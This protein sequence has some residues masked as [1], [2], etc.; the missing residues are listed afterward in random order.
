MRA[1]T[2]WAG[3]DFSLR[4]VTYLCRSIL[5]ATIHNVLWHVTRLICIHTHVRTES[6]VCTGPPPSSP[7]S[8]SKCWPRRVMIS[9]R[10]RVGR[11]GCHCE[12]SGAMARACERA[13]VLM[14]TID[15]DAM[16]KSTC[17]CVSVCV[18][19]CVCVCMLA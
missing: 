11:F 13:D 16:C 4:A 17:V 2:I 5:Y 10:V 6:L 18:C 1:S 19:E 8:S 9:I 3:R 15:V 14:W 12:C 7:P